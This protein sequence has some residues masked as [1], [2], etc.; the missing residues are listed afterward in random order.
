MEEFEKRNGQALL[1]KQRCLLLAAAMAFSA[2]STFAA[3]LTE[4]ALKNAVATAPDMTG[5]GTHRVKFK[6]GKHKNGSGVDA[7]VNTAVGDLN[8]DGVNDG[9][10]VYYEEWGGSGAFMRMSVFLCKNGK[11]S[12]IGERTLGDRSNTRNL[13]IKK[14]V[15]TLDIMA[16]GPSDSANDPTVHK[17]LKYRV[18]NQKLIGPEK[19][20]DWI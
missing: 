15:L 3:G 14:Q 18:K 11:P 9:A 5:A 8:G 19:I 17:V 13:F 12:Q 1:L 20:N 4:A 7:I 6:N 2:P 10:I 16:H